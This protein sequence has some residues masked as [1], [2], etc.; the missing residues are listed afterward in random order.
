MI[1][2]FLIAIGVSA[3]LALGAACLLFAIT[4]DME[5]D[6]FFHIEEDNA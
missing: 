1:Q 2:Y 5:P 4:K 6:D 3:A